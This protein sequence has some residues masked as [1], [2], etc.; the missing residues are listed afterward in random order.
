MTSAATRFRSPN[1]PGNEGGRTEWRQWEQWRRWRPRGKGLTLALLPYAVAAFFGA[2]IWGA[3]VWTS[4]GSA[5]MVPLLLLGWVCA[6][7]LPFVAIGAVVGSI[8][9]LGDGRRDDEPGR[10]LGGI[11]GLTLILGPLLRLLWLVWAG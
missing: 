8:I 3:S 6:I 4:A 9:D 1:S 2:C 7:A 11:L 5:M 10:V